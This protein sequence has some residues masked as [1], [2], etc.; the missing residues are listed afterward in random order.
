MTFKSILTMSNKRIL[1]LLAIC[2]VVFA[3]A[4]LFFNS[5]SASKMTHTMI[6][7]RIWH[8]SG[9][10]NLDVNSKLKVK[11]ILNAPVERL[12]EPLRVVHLDLKGAAPKVSYFQQIFPLISNL[13]ANGI[14]LEYDDMFPYEGDLEVLRSPFAYNV[15]ELNEI[16]WLAGLYNLELIPLVQVFGNLEFVLKHEQFFDLRDVGSFQNS[17]NILARGSLKLIKEMLTQVLKRH[18]QTRWFHIGAHEILDHGESKDSNNWLKQNSQGTRLLLISYMTKV[19]QFLVELKPG[20]KPIFWEDMLRNISLNLIEEFDLSSIASPM[21]WKYDSNIDVYQ[22]V[23]LLHNYQ[24]AGFHTVWFAS[25]FKGTSGISQRWTP[26]NYHLENHL[27]WLK[28]IASISKH[29]I[30]QFGG[31]VLTGWQRYEHQTV[32][33]ELFPVAIPSLAICLAALKYGSINHTAEIQLQRLLGCN[34]TLKNNMCLNTGTFAG[35]EI[36]YMVHK[37]HSELENSIIKITKDYHLKGP[38]SPEQRKNNSYPLNIKYFKKEL[39]RLVK[40]WDHF[41]KNFKMEM[42]AIYFPDTVEKWMKENVNQ[43]MNEL[44]SLAKVV[45]SIS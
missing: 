23:N 30:I 14:L 41:M 35:S 31:I 7:G 28:V 29:S 1:M 43:Y 32:L 42:I 34:V 6:S 11:S 18:P 45:E 21:I 17:L 26:I 20:I 15:E 10:N 4:K 24:Q 16:K 3:A 39:T 33:C 27:A 2:L 25:A 13:G 36:Y 22:M 40:E 37:I 44:H 8:L 19:C 12:T 5:Q 38:F 9:L